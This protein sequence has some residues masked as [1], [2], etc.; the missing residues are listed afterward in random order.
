MPFVTENIEILMF[1]I[2]LTIVVFIIAFVTMSIRY[3]KLRKSYLSMLKG[4]NVPDFEKVMIQVHEEISKLQTN[5]A[6]QT[7]QI[8]IIQGS[9]KQLKANIGIKRYNAYNQQGSDLSFSLAIVD[10]YL[11][12]IVLT[13]LHS[14]EESYIYA[15]PLEKGSS[16]YALSPEEKEA[17]HQ[18]VNKE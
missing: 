15:K 1:S 3:T 2:L 16:T 13:G 10:D 17:I 14:R 9:I 6:Q 4:T 7:K 5:Q 12:G 8:E 11:S 18:A